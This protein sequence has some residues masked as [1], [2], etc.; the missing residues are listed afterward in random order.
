MRFETSDGE[1]V[2]S[3]MGMNQRSSFERYQEAMAYIVNFYPSEVIDRGELYKLNYS[4][5]DYFYYD[6]ENLHHTHI[7]FYNLNFV[8]YENL[9]ANAKVNYVKLITFYEELENSEIAR[10]GFVENNRKG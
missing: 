1:I 10:Y 9:P 3:I 6:I 8:D 5:S 4:F 7:P 2:Y